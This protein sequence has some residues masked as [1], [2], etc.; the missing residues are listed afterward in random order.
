MRVLLASSLISSSRL[1]PLFLFLILK[2]FR[3]K[4]IISILK[5]PDLVIMCV[6]QNSRFSLSN[7][8]PLSFSVIFF[9]NFH[10]LSTKSHILYAFS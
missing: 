1:E 3:R 2:K 6:D 4:K 7:S 10:N 9:S 8:C 5:F